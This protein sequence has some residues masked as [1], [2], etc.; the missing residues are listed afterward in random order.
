MDLNAVKMF[1][2]VANTGSLSAGAEKLGM[3]LPTLSRR[4]GELERSLNVQ[5]LERNQRGITLTTSGQRLFEQVAN[6]IENL[7]AAERTIHSDMQHMHGKLRLSLP[8]GFDF[9]GELL[10][11]F[12]RQYPRIQIVCHFTDVRLDLTA[13]GIDVALRIGDLVTDKV[14]A[15]PLSPMTS[16]LVAGRGFV[17]KHGTPNEMVDLD[18]YPLAGYYFSHAQTTWWIDDK[19]Y[20]PKLAFAANNFRVLLGYALSDMAICEM[21]A[22]VAKSHLQ[23]G[24]LVQVLGHLSN[25]QFAVHHIYTAYRYPSSI[26]RTYLDFCDEWLQQRAWQ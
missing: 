26:V 10:T 16:V 19:P 3:P 15:R 4:I 17:A 6:S 24:A 18:D 9:W 7:N 14:I 2:V 12:Q 22:F 1:V 8:E 23:S 20:L 11:D 25:K 5:L 21:P 13:D